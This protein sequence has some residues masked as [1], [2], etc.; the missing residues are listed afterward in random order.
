MVWGPVCLIA[1]PVPDGREKNTKG[2]EAVRGATPQG[3]WGGG[4]VQKWMPHREGEDAS[5][6]MGP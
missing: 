5:R 4:G 6:G 2:E 1:L 3:R